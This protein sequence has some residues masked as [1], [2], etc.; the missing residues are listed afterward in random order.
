MCGPTLASAAPPVDANNGFFL[1]GKKPICQQTLSAL[2]PADLKRPL[3]RD[4]DS[5]A[6]IHRGTWRAEMPSYHV[7][8]RAPLLSSGEADDLF[9]F[10]LPS[11]FHGLLDRKENMEV[12]MCTGRKVS[13]ICFIQAENDCHGWK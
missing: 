9:R 10:S 3:E 2:P 5:G 4:Q 13:Y 6:Q 11:C 8:V 12:R 1:T 7:D